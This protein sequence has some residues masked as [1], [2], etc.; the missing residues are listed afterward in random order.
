VAVLEELQRRGI[1]LQDACPLAIYRGRDVPFEVRF[2]KPLLREGY[3]RFVWPS[4]AADHP[5][6]VWVIGQGVARALAGMPGID[7]RRVISQPRDHARHVDGL[8][9]LCAGLAHFR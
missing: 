3:T 8:R 9:R 5:E 1:W 6:E 7:S 2:Y 4:V